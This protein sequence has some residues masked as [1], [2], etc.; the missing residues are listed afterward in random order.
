M[1]GMNFQKLLVPVGAIVLLALAWRSHG[2]GGVAFAG[3]VIVM[4]LLMHFNRM[5]Q[6]L[7]RAGDRPIGHVASAVMLNAKLKQGVTL[8]HV[9]AM[10][11]ALGELRSPQD[12]QPELYRWTDAGGSYVDAVFNGGKLQSW[13]LTRPEA[14]ADGEQP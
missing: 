2:W 3:G 13:T 8:M 9:I 5:M 7:K 12:E 6:V 1:R 11:R 4:F 10:T 14:T